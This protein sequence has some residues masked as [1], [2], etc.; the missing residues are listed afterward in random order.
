MKKGG[1]GE[2]GLGFGEWGLSKGKVWAVGRASA[3][4]PQGW[5]RPWGLWGVGLRLKEQ[6]LV[7]EGGGPHLGAQQASW[8]RVGGANTL[9]S[10]PAPPGGPLPSASR[11]LPGLPPVPPRTRAAWRGVWRTGGPHLGAQ[12]ASWAR[13]GRANTLHSSPTPPGWLLPPAPPHLPTLRGTN[14]VWPPLLPLSVSLCPT[15]SPWGSSCLLGC[16]SPPPAASRCPSCGETLT[17]RLP[18][19]PS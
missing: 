8:A 3:Q 12:Q 4:D 6:R 5:K 15:G 17:P 13:V 2:K 1:G 16:Q 7:S 18:A 10:S 19:P 14:P 9:L 11:D